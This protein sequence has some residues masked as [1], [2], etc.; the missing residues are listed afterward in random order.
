MKVPRSWILILSLMGAGCA[1]QGWPFP[2]DSAVEVTRHSFLFTS[3]LIP[4]HEEA[5]DYHLLAFKGDASRKKYPLLVVFH[6]TGQKGLSYLDLWKQ[7]AAD[8][9]F[10]VAAPELQRS[11]GELPADLEFLRSFVQEVA[12]LYPVDRNK[13]VLAGVSSGA[14]MVRWLANQYPAEW[15]A[16]ILIASPMPSSSKEGQPYPPFLFV[17]GGNDSAF[18]LSGVLQESEKLK[19]LGIRVNLLVFKDA[20][21]E[22]KPEW[23]DAILDWVERV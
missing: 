17:H 1:L 16:I 18:P 19:D 3:S 13:I 4:G 8:H 10:M 20:G 2:A 23:T 22:Q 12:R 21:H 5:L 9:G 14:A 6:G 15:H 7:G 11:Y